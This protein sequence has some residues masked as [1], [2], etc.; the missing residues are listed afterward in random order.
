M[1]KSNNTRM[2]VGHFILKNSFNCLWM[3][4]LRPL[5]RLKYQYT[6]Y[7]NW[8]QE[9]QNIIYFNSMLICF[10]SSSQTFSSVVSLSLSLSIFFVHHHQTRFQCEDNEKKE[11]FLNLKKKI[12]VIFYRLNTTRENKRRSIN[13]IEIN[14]TRIK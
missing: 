2:L 3:F 10:L 1:I 8:G 11:L 6:A 4:S 12:R 7:N 14:Y 5:S 9:E 13:N